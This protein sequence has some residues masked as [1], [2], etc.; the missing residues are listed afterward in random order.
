MASTKPFVGID[1]GGTNMQIGI[2]DKT[3][4]VLGRSRKKTSADQ[5]KD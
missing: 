2:V 3:G 5:G 4:A 1:L